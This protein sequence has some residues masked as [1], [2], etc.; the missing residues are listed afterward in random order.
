M[1]TDRNF[2]TIALEQASEAAEHGETPVGAVVVQDG[3]I[4]VAERNR[5]EELRDA[6][7]HAEILA[8]RRA[9]EKLG[10]WRLHGCAIYVTL[11][12]CPMCAG[13]MVQA[14]LRRLVYGARDPKA[15][16]AGTLYNIVQDPRLN[17]RLE[18]T[19]GV[20]Q[21]QCAA[22]LQDFFRKRRG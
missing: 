7:A 4:I 21:D 15:G 10:G 2:M 12:P 1:E 14:R 11:E 3:I 6:T 17:H 19:G 13:A 20:L 22:L 16:A 8:L 9:N 18:V 5:R